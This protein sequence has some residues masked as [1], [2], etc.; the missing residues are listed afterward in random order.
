ML[1]QPCQALRRLRQLDDLEPQTRPRQRTAVNTQ[2][3][4]A[5]RRQLLEHVADDAVVGG[6]GRAEHRNL[7]AERLE[8]VLT[9]R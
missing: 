5:G 4:A 7:G 6:G 2:R 8:H 3:L 9:R 1:D